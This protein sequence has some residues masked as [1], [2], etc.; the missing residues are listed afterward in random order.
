MKKQI[1]TALIVVSLNA[2]AQKVSSF[3]F[4]SQTIKTANDDYR[5]GIDIIEQKALIHTEMGEEEAI[6]SQMG[7]L[8]LPIQFF[9]SVIFYQWDIVNLKWNL[10]SGFTNFIYDNNNNV[11][12]YVRKNWKNGIWSNNSRILDTFDINNNLC[13]YSRQLWN[14]STWGNSVNII[15][16]FNTK[17]Q[18]ISELLKLWSNEMWN[19]D[20]QH[21]YSYDANN[22]LTDNLLQ[23][24]SIFSADWWNSTETINTYDLSGNLTS[25]QLFNDWDGSK[26]LTASQY[27][28]TYDSA[29]NMTGKLVQC[30]QDN[31]WQNNQQYIYA[32]D[33][34]NNQINET[35]QR[36]VGSY[37]GNLSQTQN[38]YDANH[39][40]LS[41]FV[42]K[43]D[44]TKWM[45]SSQSYRTYDINNFQ[46]SVSNI[47]W[48]ATGKVVS[49]D[50]TC[51]NYRTLYTS[52]AHNEESDFTIFPNPSKGHFFYNSTYRVSFVEV[53]NIS[54][55]RVYASYNPEPRTSGEI[56]LMEFAKGVYIM[57][58]QCSTNNYNRKV[59]IQ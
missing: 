7:D 15:Y 51:W 42:Q 20:S 58:V 30:L 8:P 39:N 52:L 49:G 47:S 23:V 50:S 55:K 25:S 43:W 44:G 13:S 27:N 53:Y 45:N 18:K 37:W 34:N 1:F 19:F 2:Y 3:Q 54:G 41:S 48:D 33:T 10:K 9:D 24:Y 32:Y 59:V 29:Q 14:G 17:N 57:K 46:K 16:T 6:V 38:T 31:T 40:Q 12:S 11:V 36:W 21:K 5:K 22:N 28:Y 56:D 35:C 26:W 4:D